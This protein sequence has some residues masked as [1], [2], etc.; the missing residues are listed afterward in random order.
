MTDSITNI[1][2][3]AAVELVG[4]GAFLLDVRTSEEFELGHSAQATHV[5]L[6][7][8]LDRTD[9]L[10]RDK[11]IV[12]ICRSGGRSLRAAEFLA[13]EG[14]DVRNVDGG[15]LAWQAARYPMKRDG[16]GDAIVE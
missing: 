7:E 15:M 14:F 2:V 5:A 13:E 4:S 9:E 12:C 1:D 10:P 6:H 11:V 8:L 16:E 3:D